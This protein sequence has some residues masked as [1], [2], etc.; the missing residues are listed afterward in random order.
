MKIKRWLITWSIEHL[1]FAITC[2]IIRR[3]N[4]K[5]LILPVSCEEALKGDYD[6][7]QPIEELLAELDEFFEITEEDLK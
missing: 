7:D 2:N 6:E 5:A 3:I 4:P 1:G